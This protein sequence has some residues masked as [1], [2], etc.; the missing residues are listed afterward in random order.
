MWL[1]SCVAGNAYK[2]Q[3]KTWLPLITWFHHVYLL[4]SQGCLWKDLSL[5]KCCQ[6]SSKGE[7][8]ASDLPEVW[9]TINCP[10]P[11]ARSQ[12]FPISSFLLV[13]P[14][15]LHKC[16]ALIRTMGNDYSKT[17]VTLGMGHTSLHYLLEKEKEM[18]P[19]INL[20]KLGLMLASK[21]VSHFM[22]GSHFKLGLPFP[23]PMSL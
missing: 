22:N 3:G 10:L 23:L 16:T 8:R 15:L 11:H 19:R 2:S 21:L 14:G 18:P 12:N 20:H 1:L 4:G 9:N 6:L 7:I 17:D 13:N 5:A